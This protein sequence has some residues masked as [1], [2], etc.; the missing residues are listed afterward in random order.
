[1][2][3]KPIVR[4]CISPALYELY[5]QQEGITVVVDIF[6][7]TSA[8]C[9]ALQNGVNEVIPVASIHDAKRYAEDDDVI[10]AAERGGEVVD[11]FKYGNSPLSYIDNP[12]IIGKTLVLTTTNGTQAIDAAKND[13]A[14]VIGA[15]CNLDVLTAWLINENQDVMILCSGWKNRLNLEDSL[16]AGAVVDALLNSGFEYDIDSDA[17][18]ITRLLYTSSGNDMLG[19]LENSSHRNRLKNLHLEKDIEYCLQRNTCHVVPK[20]TGGAIKNI[21]KQ[22]AY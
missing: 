12:E 9:T 13:G 2:S 11:G 21:L 4:V 10:I 1:M 19:F 18:I 7:A 5:R 3:K 15:F 17:A 22:P 14:L 8:I 20:L 6:R 16:F